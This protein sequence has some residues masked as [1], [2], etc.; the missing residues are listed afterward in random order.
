MEDKRA[1]IGKKIQNAFGKSIEVLITKSEKDVNELEIMK[2]DFLYISKAV[3]NFFNEDKTDTVQDKPIE[4]VEK[5]EPV[6]KDFRP[7]TPIRPMKTLERPK[8]PIIV[9]SKEN[10]KTPMKTT[11]VN[12]KILKPAIGKRDLT[13]TPVKTDKKVTVNKTI[14]RTPNKTA[15]GKQTSIKSHTT[16]FKK[17]SITEIDAPPKDISVDDVMNNSQVSDNSMLDIINHG[18][19]MKLIKSEEKLSLNGDNEGVELNIPEHKEAPKSSRT[20]VSSK[21]KTAKSFSS[22]QLNALYLLIKSRYL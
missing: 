15:T 8:T 3:A 1:M 2:L 13:P 7:V 18:K 11:A 14:D 12:A 17:K 10:N 16:D 21:S 22:V 20:A 19:G 5:V 6:K 9:P 4:K